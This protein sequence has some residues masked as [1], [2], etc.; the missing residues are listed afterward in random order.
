MISSNRFALYAAVT[1]L[2]AAASQGY[3]QNQTLYL[4][5]VADG[6]SPTVQV[7]R[8]TI[9]ITNTSS[10]ASSVASMSF[11]ADSGGGNSQPWNLSFVEAPTFPL[12]V[13]AG[14]T[15]LLHTPATSTI[16]ST[17][18]GAIT[19]GPG[20]LA[21][22]IFSAS[23]PGGITQD[24]T[25]LALP[26]SSRF[27]V[28]FDQTSGS[29]VGL[30][31]ANVS[32]TATASIT[33]A[34]RT[35]SG[36]TIQS[37]LSVPALGHYAIDMGAPGSVPS[38]LSSIATAISGQSGLM[39]IYTTSASL[40]VLT[41]RFNST[42]AFT[43]APVYAE[44]GPPIIGTAAGSTAAPFSE[45]F[46]SG[47]WALSATAGSPVIQI[48]PNANGTYTAGVYELQPFILVSFPGGTLSGQTITFSTIGADGIFGTSAATAGS[49][50]VTVNNFDQVGSPVSGTMSLTNSSG[51]S[52]GTITGSSTYQP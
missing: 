20:V 44:A 7:W 22:A 37:T 43:A 15:I 24:G 39:E 21:Y 6:G 19:A 8:T 49:L 30:A 28:P 18:W 46:V 17:G 38:A 5:Q 35:A 45:L 40:A 2:L 26:G 16:T 1:G 23:V 50:T 42:G 27:L 31:L 4:P 10:V 3:A 52:S 13:P 12:T 51:T 47:T 32:P 14:A 29:A 34:A 33:V 9:V 41:L 48:T 25:G 36:T 11:Y